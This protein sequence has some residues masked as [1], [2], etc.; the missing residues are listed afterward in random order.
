MRNVVVALIITAV[1]AVFIFSTRA[2]PQQSSEVM[3]SPTV[4]IRIATVTIQNKTFTIE[5]ADSPTERAK[6]LSQRSSLDKDVG[7]L[8]IFENEG[9][10][11][12]WM[13]D[14]LIPLD[15]IFINNNRVTTIHKNVQPQPNVSENQLHRYAPT[16][17]VTFVL[18]INGGLSEV[19]GFRVG[20]TVEVKDVP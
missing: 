15:M 1:I 3:P 13:K 8:F 19:H 9:M 20:D 14:T 2:Q 10:H 18:E 5:I 7:L 17:P 11:T 6:G 4:A 16:E 12:F